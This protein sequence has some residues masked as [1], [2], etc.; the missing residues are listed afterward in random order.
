MDW[1]VK[2]FMMCGGMTMVLGLVAKGVKPMMKKA[3]KWM[4]SKDHPEVRQF[5]LDHREWIEAQFDA[6]DAAAKEAMDEEAATPADA[7]KAQ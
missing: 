6:A 7:P 3:I 2:L 4:I 5:V 1:K